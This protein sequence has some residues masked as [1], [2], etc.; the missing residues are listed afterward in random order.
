MLILRFPITVSYTHL[1]PLNT[2]FC[3]TPFVLLTLLYL[4]PADE[5]MLLRD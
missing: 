1:L 4:F 5:L 2:L 3:L